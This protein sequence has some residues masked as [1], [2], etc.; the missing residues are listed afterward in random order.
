MSA[1]P[2]PTQFDDADRIITLTLAPNQGPMCIL[3]EV[4]IQRLEATLK[5]LPGGGR[6]LGLVL[7]SGSPRVFIAG[8][9]LKSISAMSHADLE[10]YLAFGQR[11]FGMLCALPFPTVAAINGAALGGGLELA[12]H[13]DG[14]VAAPAPLRE[15]VS[16]PYPVG[17]PEAGLSICPGWGGTNLLPARLR[18]PAAA[19]RAMCA[20]KPWPVDAAAELGLF[21]AV[22]TSGESLLADAKAWLK[23][24]PNVASQRRDGLPLR[25]IGRADIR[26][27]VA[28]ALTTLRDE[29]AALPDA[30]QA[31]VRALDAGQRDGWPAAL[32][33]ERE[34]LNRL[35]AAPAGAT[36]ITAFFAKAAAR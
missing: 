2:L 34:E 22:A 25:W 14:L 24:N 10:R 19:I 27:R 3:D 26:A 11:V 32:K 35:R 15:G 7:A 13:C 31:C 6:A 33:V 23:G 17:L 12:M 18:D 5:S 1:A 16:K 4:L 30:G 9:D 29:L 21:D 20:G 8:A 36:A 28:A